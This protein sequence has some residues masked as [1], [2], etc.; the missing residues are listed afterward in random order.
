MNRKKI[1]LIVICLIISFVVYSDDRLSITMDEFKKSVDDYI[2]K[3]F[4]IK[5][6][7]TLKIIYGDL[8]LF[9]LV[10]GYIPQMFIFGEKLNIDGV[11]SEFFFLEIT[12]LRFDMQYYTKNK[13]L[14]FIDGAKFNLYAQF[15][16][17][18]INN[19]IKDKK[20][21]SNLKDPYIKFEK[22]F[23]F[24]KGYYKSRFFSS[25][26]STKATFVL[27][28]EKT[29]Y[30]DADFLKVGFFK[31]PGF[32]VRSVEKNVNPILD[33][34]KMP[35]DLRLKEIKIND[36]RLVISS[37]EGYNKEKID[38]LISTLGR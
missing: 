29:V 27:K 6:D 32:V 18:N 26:L 3:N 9:N 19:M 2:T 21:R 1:F 34:N 20:N 14:K 28:D 4:Q 11:D 31:L 38:E 30:I 13:E 17:K 33:L 25:S 15:T 10:S 22:D 35:F 24:V 7:E 8:G 36:Q 23:V 16:E 12:S 5:D 37:F